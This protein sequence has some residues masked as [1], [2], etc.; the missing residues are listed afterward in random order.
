MKKGKQQLAPYY[1]MFLNI[2]KKKCVVIGGGEVA[3]RKVKMLLEHG[4]IVKVIGIDL[5][6]GLAKLAESGH[7]MALRRSYREGDLSD[8]F[9]AFAATDNSYINKEVAFEARQKSI[10][11]NIADDP[12]GC[13]FIVPSY[14]KRGNIKVAISTGGLS[15][16]LARK[17]RTRLEKFIGDEYSILTQLINEVRSEIKSQG[18]AV[19]NDAWQEAMN[20]DMLLDLILNG[21]MQKAKSVLLNNLNKRKG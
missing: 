15:P 11:V 13:D 4:A 9:I 1:P 12:E 21:D 6:T 7:V 14:V 10:L 8:A 20:L 19:N 17:L 5:C 18:L 3:L 16:A 2:D